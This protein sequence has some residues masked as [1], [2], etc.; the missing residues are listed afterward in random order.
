MRLFGFQGG[1]RG[2][3]PNWAVRRS[4]ARIWQPAKLVE[5][6]GGAFDS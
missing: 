3:V 4:G 6:E 5:S 1:V 2:Q